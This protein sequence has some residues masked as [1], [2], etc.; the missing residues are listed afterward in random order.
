MKPTP[1]QTHLFE[2]FSAAQHEVAALNREARAALTCLRG[3][4]AKLHHQDGYE[5]VTFDTSPKAIDAIVRSGLAAI[6]HLHKVTAHVDAAL[7]ALLEV[8]DA[9]TAAP[10]T[11]PPKPAPVP[12]IFGLPIKPTSS[13]QYGASAT[14]LHTKDEGG[15][16][17]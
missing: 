17:D 4:Q 5:G 9:P 12:R 3:M 7:T 16:P 6:N 13:P 10:T 8:E 11:A 14:A 15:A 1:H 2:Q